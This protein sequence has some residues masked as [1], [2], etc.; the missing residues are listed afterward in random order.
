MRQVAVLVIL[1]VALAACGGSRP[2]TS[3]SSTVPTGPGDS[4]TITIDLKADA[5]GSRDAIASLSEV[6]VDTKALSG[7]GLTYTIDFGDGFTATAASAKHVYAAPATYT[8]TAT[9]TDPQGRKANATTEIAVRDVTGKWFHAGYLTTTKRVEVR[10][11]SIEAQTGTTVR[12]TYRVTGNADRTFT[13]T[14]IPPR[15]I[16]MTANDGVSLIGTLPGRLNDDA[17][18]WTLISGGDSADGQRLDFHAITGTPDGSP[19]VASLKLVFDGGAFG[20]PFAGLTPI[21]FDGTAS[22]GTALT[23]FIEFG[24][25]TAASETHATR[26]MGRTC[27]M[28]PDC[29]ATARVTVVDRFGRSDAASARYI[30]FSLEG[31]AYGAYWYASD[32]SF[33]LSFAAPNGVSYSGVASGCYIAPPVPCWS[34]SGIRATAMMSGIRDVTITI[35]DRGLIFRGTIGADA[36]MTLV[37]QSGKTLRLSYRSSY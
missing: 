14:L 11:L 30:T 2:P 16:R 17:V 13:G 34:F 26:V 19:P 12:G 18:T 22:R 36:T 7:A 37:D 31:G 3:P 28:E 15:D 21:T 6:S 24:D 25:G 4:P 1:A 35:P 23:S 9:V 10:N 20:R 5:A 33:G 8:V 32:V 29:E 27:A